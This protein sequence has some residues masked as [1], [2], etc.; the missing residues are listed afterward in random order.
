MASYVDNNK[1]K[2]TFI[3]VKRGVDLL[4]ECNSCQSSRCSLLDGILL[5]LE[6]NHE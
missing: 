1:T 5:C 4:N 6:N 2:V 3:K